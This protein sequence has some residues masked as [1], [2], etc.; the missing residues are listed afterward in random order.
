M[1]IFD[2]N[3]S[4]YKFGTL[5]FDLMVLNLL[6]ILSTAI[7]FGFTFGVS[8][9]AMIYTIY[10][11]IRKDQG[12]LLYHFVKSI[13]TNLKQGI[14]LSIMISALS[15]SATLVIKNISIFEK[16]ST[17]ILIIQY[18][19]LFETSIISL[20]LF[21]MLAKIQMNSKEA[22]VNSFFLAH[23]HLLTSI[24]CLS[25]IILNYYIIKYISPVFIVLSFGGTGYIIERLILENI[26]IEKYVSKE[27][28]E[29]LKISSHFD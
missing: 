29:E 6:F 26:I 16:H 9:I 28:K 2:M 21:P 15:L 23:R 17:L 20:Y 10:E 7:G 8:F 14:L 18:M 12:R 1:K 5:I 27:L 22:I 19:L 11:S 4:F 25:L 24:S 3:S 13:K